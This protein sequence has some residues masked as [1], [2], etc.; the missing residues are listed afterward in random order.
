[1]TTITTT[2]KPNDLVATSRPTDLHCSFNYYSAPTRPKLDDLTIIAGASADL[3][4]YTLP[5]TDLRSLSAPISGYNHE[6]NG[7]QVLHQELPI[8]SSH[9]SVHDNKVMTTQYYPAIKSLLKKELGLR[10]VAVINKTL[11]DV[12]SIDMSTLD[13]KNPR[14]LTSTPPFFI[15]HSDYTAAG[16]R[17]HFRAI[18]SDWSEENQ[19]EEERAEF[20]RLRDEIIAA[21]DVAIAKAGL[22]AGNGDMVAGKGGHWDWD[23]TGYDGPRYGIFSVWRPWETV[24]RDPLALMGAAES[25]LDYAVLP[26]S[27]KNRPGHVKS[28]YSEN[29]IVRHPGAREEA[30]HKWCYLSEQKPEE[31]YAI[32]LYDSEAL[33]RKDESVRLMCPH[34][35]FRIDGTEDAPPRRSCEL[36]VWCIW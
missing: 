5:V 30:K 25:D 9:E 8:D 2:S 22:G 21:E 13:L 11:R 18:T 23:G 26:R 20:L 36:R 14:Q 1:M 34:S 32:K 16:A 6:A 28:Y 24:K 19:T 27:Y 15:S 31:V 35:A 7:F 17:A 4:S 33:R 12:A 29:P 10:S 3:S